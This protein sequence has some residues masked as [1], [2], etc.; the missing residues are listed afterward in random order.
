MTKHFKL[1]AILLSVIFCFSVFTYTVWAVDADGD[2][3]DDITGEPID[4]DEPVYTDPVYTEPP[5]DPTDE[6]SNVDPTDEPSY[7]DPTD[8]PSYVDPTD[9]PSYEEPQSSWEPPIADPPSYV[10]GGQTYVPP[11]S[12]APSVPLI[13]AE[14][15]IDVNELSSND[16]KD[17]AAKLKNADASVDDG[18]DFS[19]IQKNNSAGDNGDWVLILGIVFVI[20][21]I[22]GIVYFIASGVSL[23]KKLAY[24]GSS[25]A[26]SKH[27]SNAQN[28]Y[29]AN[30]DYGDGYRVSRKEEKKAERNRRYD[31][32][33]IR[34]PKNNTRNRYK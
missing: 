26:A 12:T 10:G 23:R 6:P 8:E 4:G 27:S 32:A 14:H 5:V 2:G 28:R 31:T 20:F 11:A 13:D 15:N 33:D 30:D 9:E 25:G 19:F 3:Y 16:W 21:S 7:V 22:A 24:A 29:R 1:L 34:L 17:I 18:D